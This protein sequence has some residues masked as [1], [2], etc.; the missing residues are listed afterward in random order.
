MHIITHSLASLFCVYGL[1]PWSTEIKGD[2]INVNIN[3]LMNLYAM[4][5]DIDIQ[6]GA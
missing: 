1:L 4:H 6:V 5:P 3:L 2:R